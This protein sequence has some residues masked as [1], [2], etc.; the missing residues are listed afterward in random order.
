MTNHNVMGLVFFFAKKRRNLSVQHIAY[1][2]ERLVTKLLM[3]NISL[4]VST[5][6][7][8]YIK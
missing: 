6:T 4:R 7:I 5:N 2:V 1:L 8:I 3:I